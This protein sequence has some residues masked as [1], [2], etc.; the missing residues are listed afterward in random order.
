[1]TTKAKLL[2]SVRGGDRVTALFPAGKSIK[3]GK[4]VQDYKERSGYANP[5]LIFPGS[6][7]IINLG[8]RYGTP[9]YVDASNIVRVN[10][11]SFPK[12]GAS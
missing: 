6:H 4:I 10:G 3:N 1:M 8:G 7:V 5:L 2:A 12:G 11:R 9:G